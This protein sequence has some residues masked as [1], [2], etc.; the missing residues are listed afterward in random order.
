MTAVCL[1]IVLVAAALVA[2]RGFD[3]G[4]ADRRPYRAHTQP[5]LAFKEGSWWNTPLPDNAPLDPYGTKILRYM[6]TARQNGG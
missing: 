4:Y 2:R 1:T 5:Y 3:L 6:R